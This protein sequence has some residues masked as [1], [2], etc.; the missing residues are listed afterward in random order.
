MIL[1][2]LL[3]KGTNHSTTFQ[4][5]ISAYIWSH[6]Y[7][8]VLSIAIDIL[9]LLLCPHVNI[10]NCT[11]WFKT[12]TFKWHERPSFVCYRIANHI[13]MFIKPWRKNPWW[14]VQEFNNNWNDGISMSLHG[15]K[16]MLVR[17][18]YYNIMVHSNI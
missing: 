17:N 9:K 10:P 13:S 5:S 6:G 4:L 18:P 2:D 8:I 15:V 12:S 14:L 7:H 1:F 16:G 3:T 11:H